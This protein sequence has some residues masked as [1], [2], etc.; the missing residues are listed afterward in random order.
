MKNE[1]VS[2]EVNFETL[3]IL[4]RTDAT[5]ERRAED[6]LDLESVRG[7]STCT[8]IGCCP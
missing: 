4:A 1:E 8:R 6:P 2:L 3:A 7:T 5:A